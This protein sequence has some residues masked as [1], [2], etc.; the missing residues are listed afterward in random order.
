MFIGPTPCVIIKI[1]WDHMW[2]TLDNLGTVKLNKWKLLFIDSTMSSIVGFENSWVFFI[3][4][5]VKYT[6]IFI[7]VW[8]YFSVFL[9]A[10][11]PKAGKD[12]EYF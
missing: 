5:K 7:N 4:I 12:Y 10:K 1:Q 6:S 9:Q 2:K 11:I 8:F 3:E